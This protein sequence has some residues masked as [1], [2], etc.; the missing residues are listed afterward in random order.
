[1]DELLEV[2]SR[3]IAIDNAANLIVLFK[4]IGF[5]ASLVY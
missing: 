4:R 5:E 3:L 1:M 2:T